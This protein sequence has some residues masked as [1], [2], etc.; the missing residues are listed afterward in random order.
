[1]DTG[2][3]R[4]WRSLR[5]SYNDDDVEEGGSH[6]TSQ[7]MATCELAARLHSVG[8]LYASDVS[9]SDVDDVNG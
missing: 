9:L 7:T 5:E 1:M 4:W 8:I 3:G 2:D 6:P